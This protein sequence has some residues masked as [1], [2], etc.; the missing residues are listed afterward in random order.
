MVAEAEGY[1]LTDVTC[2]GATTDTV[3]ATQLDA[4]S[5]TTKLVT[6]TI[7]GNDLGLAEL[8]ITCGLSHLAKIL[9]WALCQEA[10]AT[11]SR[12]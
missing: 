10:L 12:S 7:G 2:G 5:P 11:R 8:G 4:L 6:L 3:I 9:A 1:A